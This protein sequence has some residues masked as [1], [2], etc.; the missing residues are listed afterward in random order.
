LTRLGVNSAFLDWIDRTIN[1]KQSPNICGVWLADS[2]LNV[3][4]AQANKRKSQG[5][6]ATISVV[7]M[8]MYFSLPFSMPMKM[9]HGI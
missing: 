3:E 5:V 7:S 8:N 2:F 1:F 6:H 4:D 9:R